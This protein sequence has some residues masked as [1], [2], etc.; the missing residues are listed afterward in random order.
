M[1]PIEK[2]C[3]NAESNRKSKPINESE[4]IS[5]RIQSFLNECARI[6]AILKDDNLLSR[7]FPREFS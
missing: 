5:P 3:L 4:K 1:G 7:L 6:I 2:A